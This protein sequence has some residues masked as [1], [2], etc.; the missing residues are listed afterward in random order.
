M[1]QR[2][3]QSKEQPDIMYKMSMFSHVIG[4]QLFHD[5][6]SE[7]YILLPHQNSLFDQLFNLT[8]PKND[9]Y[10]ICSKPEDLKLIQ[11]L[12][13]DRVIVPTG[14]DETGHYYPF[15][16]DIETNRHCN[17]QCLYC[18]QSESRKKKGVMSQDIFNNIIHQIKPYDIEWV[19]FTHYNE[20]LLDPFFTER[21]IQLREN[22]LKLYFTTN[23]TLLS[24]QVID[25]LEPNDLVGVIFNLPSMEPEEW[26]Y[27]MQLPTHLFE[28]TV[29]QME[30]FIQKFSDKIELLSIFI[31][32]TT[33]N[34]D[35]RRQNIDEH[36]S[37][38][39]NVEVVNQNSH[40]RAGSISNK[41]TNSYSHINQSHFYG[42][43]RIAGHL[44]VSW[45][46][47]C[48]LCCQD[49]YQSITLGDL[50]KNSIKDI[51]SS[52]EVKRLRGEIYGVYPMRQNLPCRQCV[53]LRKKRNVVSPI[54]Y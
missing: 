43:E 51:M 28:H 23:A 29:H 22:N 31:N 37:Q 38:F 53:Q 54:P 46:G 27:F 34:Q 11:K 17:A 24:P 52:N 40:N 15:L 44:H 1:S 39:G 12:F 2:I 47:K 18:P 10:S 14:E 32:G 16:V 50:Q 41:Y 26:S 6:N 35:P 5:I 33:K 20:P 4:N 9:F 42:C 8:G 36:F 48:F 45:E 21:V 25:L 3:H 7:E 19:A 49:Y 30:M 13:D